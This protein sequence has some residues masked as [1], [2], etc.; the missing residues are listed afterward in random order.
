MPKVTVLRDKGDNTPGRSVTWEC[1]KGA[2]ESILRQIR[3]RTRR[4]NL[5]DMTP[6]RL[7][8][9][10]LHKPLPRT[11]V[12]GALSRAALRDIGKSE[13]PLCTYMYEYRAS[14]I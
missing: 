3:K 6:Q 10:A 8:H 11:T 2:L 7:K 5:D 12:T 1:S 9:E 13:T 4:T 14:W